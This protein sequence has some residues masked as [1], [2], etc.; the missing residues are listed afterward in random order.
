[1]NSKYLI[2]EDE[3]SRILNLH[4]LHKENFIGTSLK[5]LLTE[6]EQIVLGKGG[7]PWDYKKSNGEF[8]AKK[9]RD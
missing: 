3:K 1:M 5:N 4:N 8:F 2:N 7:D 6:E 9:K